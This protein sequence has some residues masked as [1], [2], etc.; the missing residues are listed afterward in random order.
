MSVSCQIPVNPIFQEKV[1]NAVSD[2][3]LRLNINESNINESFI[4]LFF[5][6]NYE[7]DNRAA[8]IDNFFNNCIK[9]W[10]NFPWFWV[11]VMILVDIVFVVHVKMFLLEVPL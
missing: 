5:D 3:K 10:N 8:I 7:I 4:V 1:P 6:L 9:L 11:S 2:Y